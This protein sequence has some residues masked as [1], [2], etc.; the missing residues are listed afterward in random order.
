MDSI[1]TDNELIIETGKCKPIKMVMVDDGGSVAELESAY[2]KLIDRV[3]A[4]TPEK[5]VF[6]RWNKRIGTYELI[7]KRDLFKAPDE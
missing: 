2:E 6:V 5:P 7:D 1:K 3:K 4:V